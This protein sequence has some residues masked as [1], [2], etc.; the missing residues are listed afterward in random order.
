M[1]FFVTPSGQ[2]FQEFLDI[3][4]KYDMI[5]HMQKTKKKCL[6]SE[7]LA[8]KILIVNSSFWNIVMFLFWYGNDRFKHKFYIYFD[9][10]KN[11]NLR[12]KVK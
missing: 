9:L 2:V 8:V 10:K 11:D 6:K 12:V 4:K 7:I 3:L 1:N 5:T